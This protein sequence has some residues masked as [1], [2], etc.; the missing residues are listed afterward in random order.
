MTAFHPELR[1]ARLIPPLP[2]GP[3]TVRVFQRAL[4][5]KAKPAP[6]DVRIEEVVAPGREGSPNV[7][8]RIYSPAGLRVPAPAL[9]S[10]HGGG[11]IMGSPQMEDPICIGYVRQLGITVV[12]VDYRLSP[13]HVSPA[14]VEDAYTGLLWTFA[15][16]AEHSID[17]T[18]IAIGGQSAG[19]GLTAALALY[20]HDAGEVAPIFQFLVYPMLDD[21]TALRPAS[22]F[23]N[24]RIWRP[25]SNRY[26]WGAYLG[27]APGATGV[28]EYAAPARREDLSGLPPAWIGVGTLD[29]FHD[30]DV[31]Y[32]QRLRKA[33]VPCELVV[34]PGAFHGFDIFSNANVVK[35]FNAAKVEALRRAFGLVA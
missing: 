33:G 10:M 3:R 7:R 9:Y 19:G 35:Q 2:I 24:A 32:A 21:R 30:E 34:V 20:A 15:H 13:Q 1:L 11:Y 29:V 5:R 17:A 8:L 26:A 22:E 31:V 27:V 25:S 28:S 14:A 4:R 18:R 6:D 23:A 16:A 12:S